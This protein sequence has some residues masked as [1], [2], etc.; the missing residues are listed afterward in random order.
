MKARKNKIQSDSPAT[1]DAAW[2]LT[3]NQA[4]NAEFD[5]FCQAVYPDE[6]AEPEDQ[7]TLRAVWMAAARQ[8]VGQLIEGSLKPLH[9]TALQEF[10]KIV[11]PK[12]PVA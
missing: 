4:L 11:P 8:T 5:S 12:N 2:T 3:G 6:W 1:P 9:A 7:K 10:E